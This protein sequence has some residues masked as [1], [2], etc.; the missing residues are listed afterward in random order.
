M[1]ETLEDLML[2]FMRLPDARVGLGPLDPHCEEPQL[3]SVV[4]KMIDDDLIIASDPGYMSFL[5]YYAGAALSGDTL[6]HLWGPARAVRD[7]HWDD[8]ALT[9][10][11]SYT[12]ICVA[13]LLDQ[14]RV[15][16]YLS[17]ATHRKTGVYWAMRSAERGLEVEWHCASFLDLLHEIVRTRGT[18]VPG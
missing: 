12:P 15:E 7:L 1:P 16:F 2:Q 9:H 8:L 11:S 4:R 13:R 17:A 10:D 5:K 14:P 3:I 18:F 6:V